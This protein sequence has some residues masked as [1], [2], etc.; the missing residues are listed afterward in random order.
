MIVADVNVIIYLL[1]ETPQCQS[2]R[3]VRERDGEG[4]NDD[5]FN[6]YNRRR[7]TLPRT[8]LTGAA[9]TPGSAAAPLLPG[10]SKFRVAAGEVAGDG[11][12][13]QPAAKH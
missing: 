2:A 12:Y 6:R 4:I 1:T 13:Q 11:L 10:R 7:L 9:P 8:T 3:N 5:C